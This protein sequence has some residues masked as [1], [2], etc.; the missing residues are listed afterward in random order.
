MT[1]ALQCD[2]CAMNEWFIQGTAAHKIHLTRENYEDFTS[3][4]RSATLCRAAAGALPIAGKI[5]AGLA[6]EGVPG[7]PV[8]LP[9]IRAAAVILPP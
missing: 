2:L 8:H 6:G 1:F 9:A 7:H 3:R 5:N 4:D